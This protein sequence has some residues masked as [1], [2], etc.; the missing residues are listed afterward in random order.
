[1]QKQKCFNLS[2]YFFLINT[3]QRGEGAER[4]GV[5]LVAIIIHP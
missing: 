4:D 1:M 3:V 5:A 2:L